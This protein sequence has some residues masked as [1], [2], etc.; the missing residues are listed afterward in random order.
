MTTVSTASTVLVVPSTPDLSASQVKS[1]LERQGIPPQ[2]IACC[3]KAADVE[4]EPFA[5]IFL[6]GTDSS[7]L[8]ENISFLQGRLPQDI[9]LCVC[10]SSAKDQRALRRSGAHEILVPRAWLPH[11]IAERIAAALHSKS[12]ASVGQFCGIYGRTPMML[13]TFEAIQRMMRIPDPVL[14]MGES[15]TGKELVSH[16]LHGEPP[17]EEDTCKA[18]NC[19]SLTPEMIESELFG[20]VKGAFTGAI[21]DRQGLLV[22]L[23]GGTLILDEIGELTTQLQARLLRVIEEKKVRPVGSNTWQAFS[24]RL[25]AVTH[26]NLHQACI[27]G[28]FRNDL[29]QRLQSFQLTLP[30]LR[31]RR[32]DIS[33]L[34]KL[35][36][37]R[38]NKEMETRHWIKDQDFDLLVHSEWPGNVRQLQGAIREAATFAKETDDHSG[39][40]CGTRLLEAIQRNQVSTQSSNSIS[41]DPKIDTWN[42]VKYR[43]QKTYLEAVLKDVGG[44]RKDSIERTGISKARI[45]QLLN[46][47]DLK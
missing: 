44:S 33:L 21:R 28:T 22:S 38:F 1:E 16:A 12:D 46:D 23:N 26:R 6:L 31:E 24:T 7:D 36:L 25:V 41:F 39:P 43:S 30:P 13:K 9:R 47:Y 20:H 10:T 5:H 27:D 17:H 37:R 11:L 29:Y 40:V 2:Q 14:V 8:V 3:Q 18:I 42:D 19:S 15:G 45:Y 34:A 4:C 35:F 32:A